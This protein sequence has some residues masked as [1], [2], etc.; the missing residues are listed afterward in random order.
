M[1]LML[2][3]TG[4]LMSLHVGMPELPRMSQPGARLT[5]QQALQDANQTHDLSELQSV[6][7]F[8]GGSVLLK[9]LEGD[10]EQLLL[11]TDQAVTPLYPDRVLVK[12]LHEGTWAGAWSGSINL[13]GAVT[14]GLLTLTGSLS[15]LRRRRKR[16]Q[17]QTK[18][19]AL[20]AKAKA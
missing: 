20:Q 19:S 10:R 1:A 7:R 18:R 17:L 3:L 9:M 6:R 8:R 4:V 16:L 11:V 13:L 14:L 2:P 15:W 5:L 12:T